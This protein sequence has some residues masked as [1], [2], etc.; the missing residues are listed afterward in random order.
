MFLVQKSMARKS[1]GIF[2]YAWPEEY[3]AYFKEKY[4][5]TQKSSS[6]TITKSADDLT[7]TVTTM[8]ESEKAFNEFITD[9]FIVEHMAL[10]NKYNI[11]NEIEGRI[12]TKKEI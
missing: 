11:M 1:P 3:K 6:S 7:S 8:W 2:F 4:L 9:P 10:R 12:P 5:D